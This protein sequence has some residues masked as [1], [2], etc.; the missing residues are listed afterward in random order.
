M[1]IKFNKVKKF[2]GRNRRPSFRNFS[3]KH[4]PQNIMDGPFASSSK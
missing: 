4:G 1:H 3:S 2:N